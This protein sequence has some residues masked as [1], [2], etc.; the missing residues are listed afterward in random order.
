MKNLYLARIYVTL[1]PA[2]NDPQGITVLGGLKNLGF[3]SVNDVRLGKYLEIRLVEA[4]R[5]D[6][7]SKVTEMCQNLL[8]NPV[9]EDFR[10]ELV[11]VDNPP[12]G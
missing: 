8:A 4:E 12:A 10:F 11:E 2:V 9:I 5:S 6:A 3:D 1:K 7:E